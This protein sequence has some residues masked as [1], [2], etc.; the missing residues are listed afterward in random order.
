MSDDKPE[1]NDVVISK[2]PCPKCGSKKGFVTYADGHA[3]CYGAGCDHYVPSQE[4]NTDHGS[5]PS[6]RSDSRASGLLQAGPTAYPK[7]GLAKRRISTETM[8]RYGVFIN[9]KGL[10]TYPFTD[11]RGEVVCQKVRTPEKD[12]YLVKGEGYT[13][14]EDCQL[15]GQS[16]YG[17]RFDRQVI[18]TEGELDALS[19]AQVLDFKAA[20]V[21]INTGAG[22]A[23]KCLQKNYLWLDR[24]DDI[25]LFFDND[26][27]GIEAAE[28]CASLFKV[29]K[30]R[31]AKDPQGKKDASDILQEARDGDIKSAIYAATKWRP[32]GIVNARDS[33]DA[34]RAPKEKGTFY[35]WPACM[36]MLQEMTMGIHPGDVI[37]L[38]AGTGVGKSSVLGETE[39]ALAVEQDVKLGLLSFEDT[40]KDAMMRLMSIHAGE[41]LHLIPY[42]DPEDAAA[43]EV[44]DQRM[45]KVH[46]EVFAS[47]NIELFDPETAEWKLEAVMGYIR[48]LAKALECKGVVIDPMSFIA[49]GIDLTQDERRVLDMVAGELAKLSK[50]LGIFL[51]IA[52]HLKRTSQ[53]VPHEEG[54]PTSLNEL[55]SSG[56][57]ANFATG[58]IGQE[59]NA[60]AAGE[61]W[62]VTRL[63]ILKTI[64]RTGK[65]GLAD[66]LYYGEDGRLIPSPI[67]FP[68]PGKPDGD[69]SASPQR[70]FVAV[71]SNDY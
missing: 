56:A 66:T 46:A 27:P 8:R 57:L 49:S 69:D 29:G 31:I 25:V 51:I 34:V 21:S 61:A 38:V 59:R 62:R 1:G 52:H 24:F 58:V 7:A 32:K 20:V 35:N 26:E 63:R 71:G 15:F 33:A 23:Y 14:L 40:K 36:P 64:R 41:R 45:L 42:P 65:S 68:P 53:G 10:Q 5:A 22:N 44:Y 3:H 13:K 18:I 47:G 48:Y 4:G 6:A 12:F 67:P 11:S 43:M 50:E 17:E 70:G 2:G 54:A 37:Y 55:R 39:Y 19:V 9:D 28:Q 60:Q 30:V 16:V